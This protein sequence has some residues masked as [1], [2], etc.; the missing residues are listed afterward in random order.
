MN[1]KSFFSGFFA[2]SAILGI[3]TLFTVPTSGKNIRA[4][5]K[6]NT[7]KLRKELEKITTDSKHV[8]VQ[9][10]A[11]AKE[12]K[13]VFSSV[14]EEMKNS[15][16]RWQQDIEPTVSQLK[17]DIEALQRNVEQATKNRN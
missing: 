17:A 5:C 8:S 10:K 14:G 4:S 1:K 11:T 16:T 7:L 9:F 12:G 13:E 6:E 3:I 2:G 15:I